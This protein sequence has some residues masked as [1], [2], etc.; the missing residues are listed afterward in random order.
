MVILHQLKKHLVNTIIKRALVREIQ[1]FYF[2][3]EFSKRLNY[4]N[5]VR[6]GR[7]MTFERKIPEECGISSESIDDFVD[8]LYERDIP[9]HR[10]LMNML[11]RYF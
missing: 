9:M 1:L 7:N 2:K 8:F 4:F 10:L 5:N 6:N 3:N 11:E